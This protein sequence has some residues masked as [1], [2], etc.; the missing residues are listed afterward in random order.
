[1]PRPPPRSTLPSSSAASDVNKRQVYRHNVSVLKK[2]GDRVSSGEII[3]YTGGENAPGQ[4][5]NL[6][7]F[8]LWHN[9]TPVDPQG[10]IVF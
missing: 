7:E 2:A 3:G 8:E 4:D 10:Y 5:K 9:G 6:F 1:M